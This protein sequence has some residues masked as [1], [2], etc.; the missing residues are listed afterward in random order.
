MTMKIPVQLTASWFCFRLYFLI[1]RQPCATV[2]P[3]RIQFTRFM[4]R[5]N[6]IK[7]PLNRLVPS[8]LRKNWCQEKDLHLDLHFLHHLRVLNYENTGAPP[9]NTLEWI[10]RFFQ[11]FQGV[12]DA[13]KQTAPKLG[14]NFHKGLV[15]WIFTTI[16][17]HKWFA[18]Y[19]FREKKWVNLI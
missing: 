4:D 16:D 11:L 8:K 5:L 17:Y 14:S 19:T 10:L 7:N 9:T 15:R 18:G 13:R 6:Y 3:V 1:F 2:L 12:F